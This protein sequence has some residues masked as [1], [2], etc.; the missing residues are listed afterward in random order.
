MK[1]NIQT[2]QPKPLED[3]QGDNKK[4]DTSQ[5]VKEEKAESGSVWIYLYFPMIYCF[6]G[7]AISDMGVY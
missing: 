1:L 5:L 6:I 2:D 3:D 4:T 7:E